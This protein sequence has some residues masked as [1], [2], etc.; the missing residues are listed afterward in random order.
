MRRA[1]M[2]EP[3][4]QKQFRADMAVERIRVD[5]REFRAQHQLRACHSA[6]DGEHG[7]PADARRLRARPGPEPAARYRER[8]AALQAARGAAAGARA[9][10]GD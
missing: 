1:Q 4:L 9:R 10:G 7:T 6:V 5:I 2:L 8:R 3:E